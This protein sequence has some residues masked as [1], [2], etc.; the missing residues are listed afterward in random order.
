M[1]QRTILTDFT[2]GELSPKFSGRAEL[3]LYSKGCAT[4][5]NWVP[6]TQGG[7]ITRPGTQYMGTTKSGVTGRLIPFI[8]SDTYPFVV[9]F[10]NNLIRIWKDGVLQ[11]AP[12]EIATT[13]TSAQLWQIQYAKVANELFLVHPGHPIAV[14]TWLGG[15]TFSLGNLAITAGTDVPAWQATHA[16]SVDDVVTN[17]TPTKIYRCITAGTSAGSG[18]PTTEADDITDGTVHWYWEYTKPFS[19]AGDYPSAIAHFQGRMFYGGTVNDPSTTWASEPWFYGDFN[20]F[21]MISYSAT[22]IKDSSLWAN[23][24]NPETEDITVTNTVYGEANAFDFT[25]ASDNEDDIYWMVGA[26]ALIIGTSMA[27]W[28]VPPGVN[29]LNIQAKI[30][31]R[32][33]SAFV[34]ATMMVDAPVMVQGTTSRAALREYAYL[35]ESSE[36]SSPDLSFAADHMLYSG[37]TQIAYMQMPQPTVFCVSNGEIAA[38]LYNKPYSVLAWYHVILD[39]GTV[40]SVCVVPGTADDVLYAVVNRGGTRCME[41][42]G[43]LWDMTHVPLDSWVQITIA[44]ATQSGLDRFDGET[45]TIYNTTD[46]TVHTA[47]VAAGSLT[48]PAGDGVGDVVKIG[49]PIAC[50][51][52]TMNLNC[53][54]ATGPG[55]TSLKR[56]SAVGARVLTSMPFQVGYSETANLETAQ[57]DDQS[58]WTSAYT[59]NVRI[60][61]QG[62]WDREG[63]V[64]FVQNG[65]Y[66]SCIL[67]LVPEIDA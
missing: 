55:Q 28:V 7:V 43:D 56:I 13:Y 48:Y 25:I 29:A 54:T 16:Y 65:P 32:I 44:G 63:Y 14:L 52:Q 33:G 1:Y 41:K 51:G 39:G 27:E 30:R 4:L 2:A 15:V 47:A 53:Q 34:Q 18:G 49:M 67:S 62:Q 21:N 19:Q 58:A 50:A 35:A 6:F 42:F 23:P 66:R 46:S 12:L 38:M 59:G 64:W 26:D 60:S 61:F 10:T 45:V 11:G 24:L 37:C 20:Y 8:V 57:K 3:D 40:E 22:R 17:G 9:E 31:S 5:E 36:L